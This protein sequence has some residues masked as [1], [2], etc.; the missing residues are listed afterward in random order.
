MN[1][2]GIFNGDRDTA[3]DDDRTTTDRLWRQIDITMQYRYGQ[4]AAD[5]E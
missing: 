4:A 1:R 2:I 3:D 5:D